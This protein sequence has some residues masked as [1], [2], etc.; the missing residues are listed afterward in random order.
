MTKKCFPLTQTL[1]VLLNLFV[2]AEFANGQTFAAYNGDLL[3]GFRKTGSHQANYELVVNI[4]NI[5][6]F[7]KLQPGASINISNFTPSQ[8]SAA[9]SDYNN[10]QWSIASSFPGSSRWAG[11]PGATIWY[12]V[13]RA[14]ANTQS[15]E[16]ARASSSAQQL[17]RQAIVSVGAGA[18]SISINLGSSNLN[19][20]AVLVREPINDPNDLSSFIGGALNQTIGTFQDTL[21]FSVENTTSSTFNS[22]AVS[23]LYQSCPSG[24]ADPTTGSTTGAAYLVGSFQLTPDGKMTFTRAST[25]A[26]PSPPPPTVLSLSRTAN[27]TTI[28]FAT[29]NGATYTLYYTNA[30]GLGQSVTTWPAASTTITGDGSIKSFADTTTDP[31]RFYRVSG[32]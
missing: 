8:L 27:I 22:V 30:A 11:F 19:N 17:T 3:A 5:T 29:T 18:A 13:P 10:L 24:I 14:A 32:K 4:G 12:S 6:N 23:D 9:F 15:P 25:V 21:A 2:L 7:E 20:N 1:I 31:D 16:P 28:S 26:P